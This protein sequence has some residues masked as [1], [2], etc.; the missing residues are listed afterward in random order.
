MID[1]RSS[2]E[3]EVVSESSF[4]GGMGGTAYGDG[5]RG[6]GSQKKKKWNGGSFRVDVASEGYKKP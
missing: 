6:G 3:M 1:R 4:R 5:G 2:H